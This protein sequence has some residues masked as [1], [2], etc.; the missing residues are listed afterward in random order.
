MKDCYIAIIVVV[1][2]VFMFNT[3]LNSCLRNILHRI[4]GVECEP[5]SE[6][7]HLWGTRKVRLEADPTAKNFTTVWYQG[8]EVIVPDSDAFKLRAKYEYDG[9]NFD[10][11]NAKFDREYFGDFPHGI[12][13]H[14]LE[15]LVENTYASER[16]YKKV[17]EQKAEGREKFQ[18]EIENLYEKHIKV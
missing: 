11:V 3:S 5:M 10:L 12:N 8:G 4:L 6:P 13:F 17:P 9:S 18:I 14:N 1:L 16:N 7:S 2:L 15:D